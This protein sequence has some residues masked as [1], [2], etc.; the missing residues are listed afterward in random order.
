MK[1]IDAHCHLESPEFQESLDRIISDASD[2][3]IIKLITSSITIG[4][5][6]KSRALAEKYDEVEN[7]PQKFNLIGAGWGHGVGLCQ[8]GAAVMSKSG[9]TFDEI[10]SH[11]FAGSIIRKIY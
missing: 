10:L 11:Y 7:I 5:W 9:Y 3:G 6:E 1:L 2:S 8:I 4:Q